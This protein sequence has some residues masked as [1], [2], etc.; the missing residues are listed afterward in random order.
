M[1]LIIDSRELELIS[2]FNFLKISYKM[3]MLSVG[4]IIIRQKVIINAGSGAGDACG[5]AGTSMDN[6]G[7]IEDKSCITGII[8]ERKTIADLEASIIDTRY[9]E[10]RQRLIM[11]AQENKYRTMYLIEGAWSSGKGTIGAPALMKICTRLQ[12][13]HNISVLQTANIN[14]TVSAINTLKQYFIA[15]PESFVSANSNE[16]IRA[17]DGIKVRKK[18]NENTGKMFMINSLCGCSGI[19]SKMAVVI[20]ETC[21]YNWNILLQMLQENGENGENGK[22]K[23][24]NAKY[25]ENQRRIGPAVI[26]RLAGLFCEA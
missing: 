5:G 21:G 20:G 10:Q 23:L 25:G 4:D 17:S 24:A 6:T 1:E 22:R 7:N 12:L 19:S 15:N 26:D 11:F 3:E 18:D 9:K 13:H 8:F 16:I 2:I 14:E